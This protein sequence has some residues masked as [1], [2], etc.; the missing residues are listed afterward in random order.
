MVMSNGGF[1][2]IHE[3]F[4]DRPR[5]GPQESESTM[6]R[7]LKVVV[8]LAALLPATSSFAQAIQRPEDEPFVVS[9]TTK[10]RWGYADE[11]IRLF[12]KNHLP[13]LKKQ[14]DNGRILSVSAVKPRYP[15]DR[16]WSMGLSR[17]NYF[18]NLSAAHDSGGRGRADQAALSRSGDISS[19]RT[20][21]VRDSHRALGCPVGQSST[22]S[23][24]TQSTPRSPSP[25]AENEAMHLLHLEANQFRNLTG[26]ID[27]GPGLN[28]LY[29][30]NAQGKSNW[31][32]AIYLLATTKSFRTVHPREMMKHGSDESILRGV[33]AR[34]NVIKELQLLIVESSKQTFISG[35]REAVV[36]YLG[37]LDAIAFTADEL[38]IVRG[39]PEAR[40][41]FPRPWNCRDAAFISR[42]DLG[43]Q[44]CL[45]AEE[46][47]LTGC[48]RARGTLGDG[49]DDRGLERSARRPGDRYS[50][51]PGELRREASKSPS[52]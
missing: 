17:D 11:F 46:S 12:K 29:G 27:F 25:L 28:V 13:V 50:P 16:G 38:E 10:T 19:R 8:L 36:R 42:N 33:V 51:G 15:L 1:G 52:A 30:D 6:K 32:E 39:A 7:L 40:R 23:I 20:A 5:A 18:K 3:K 9:I 45:K 4:I 44:P 48:I 37:T 34:G 2:G 49:A 31:L 22:R 26:A 24:G 47:A 21:T 43:I 35:K 41:R 14:I